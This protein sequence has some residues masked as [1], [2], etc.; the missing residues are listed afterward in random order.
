MR[1]TSLFSNPSPFSLE[2]GMFCGSAQTRSVPS[3]EAALAVTVTAPARR[4]IKTVASALEQWRAS[5]RAARL[6]V[7]LDM[8]IWLTGPS[9]YHMREAW[10]PVLPRLG[11]NLPWVKA[12][13]DRRRGFLEKPPNI[14]RRTW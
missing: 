7:R 11:G 12:A 4:A 10:F 6:L 8:F 5:Q 14:G 3:V 1:S 9:A 13:E 2:N